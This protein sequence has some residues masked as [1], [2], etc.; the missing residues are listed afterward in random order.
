MRAPRGYEHGVALTLV[1]GPRFDPGVLRERRE[2]GVGEKNA[3][4]VNRVPRRLLAVILRGTLRCEVTEKRRTLAHLADEP[5][6]QRR[7]IL[8][9]EDI[10]PRALDGDVT[11][12]TPGLDV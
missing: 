10:P 9:A 8:P 11:G 12:R 6:L 2:V 3:D 7:E 5:R 4:V 1:E